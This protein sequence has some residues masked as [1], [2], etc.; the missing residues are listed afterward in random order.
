MNPTIK[1]KVRSTL[2]PGSSVRDEIALW[3][4]F[5]A[6]IETIISNKRRCSRGSIKY[7]QAMNDRRTSIIRAEIPGW[8]SFKVRLNETDE[9]TA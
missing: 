7:L 4:G 1:E 2:K 9:R 6:C 3:V 5:Y 8:P